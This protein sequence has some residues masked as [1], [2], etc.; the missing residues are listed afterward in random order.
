MRFDEA[1]AMYGLFG[2]FYV[3]LRFSAKDL[4]T[5]LAGKTPAF[6]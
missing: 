3:G 6:S 1:S 2:T 4:G 5:L